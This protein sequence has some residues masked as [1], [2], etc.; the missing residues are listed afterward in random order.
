MYKIPANTYGF[1][2]V[3]FFMLST[4]FNK[5]FATPPKGVNRLSADISS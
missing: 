3:L 5:S 2:S 1:D 4:D